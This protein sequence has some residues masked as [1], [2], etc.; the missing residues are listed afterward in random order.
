MR[1]SRRA[2]LFIF[3]APLLLAVALRVPM[4]TAALPYISYI[5]EGHVLHRVMQ[6][7][8]VGTWDPGWYRYPS[9]SMGLIAIVGKLF[10]LLSGGSLIAAIP[11]NH[12][13]YYDLIA[14]PSLILIAR[15]IVLVHSLGIITISTLLIKRLIIS[16]SVLP[17]LC[18]AVLV[19]VIP[20]LHTRSAIVIVDTLAAFY[21][22]L[23]MYL[24][25][26]LRTTD[27]ITLV[28]IL[29]GAACGLAA[30][31]KYQSGSV[32]I[33]VVAVLVLTPQLAALQR[34]KL[35]I[36][37]GCAA[38]VTAL[39]AMPSLLFRFEAVI[40]DL[41][42]QWHIYGSKTGYSGSYLGYA[43]S[44]REFGAGFLLLATAGGV[45]LF[46][47]KGQRAYIIGW[48]LFCIP[49]LILPLR[50]NYQP[51]RNILPL[52][53]PACILIGV[54]MDVALRFS[55][56]FGLVMCAVLLCSAIF[57][58]NK[59]IKTTHLRVQKIDSRAQALDWLAKAATAPVYISAE[60]V[61]LPDELSKIERSV[62]MVIPGDR[63]R[64]LFLSDQAGLFVMEKDVVH[65]DP[66]RDKKP[67]KMFGRRSL[68]DY[69]GYWR[70]NDLGIVVYRNTG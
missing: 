16:D 7:L 18:T 24:C 23:V 70:T 10:D 60:L 32:C 15:L 40:A 13:D 19:A 69:P 46:F 66:F 21:V 3:I 53:A 1:L 8:A 30:A 28:C 5:D 14:P 41:Q 65:T 36:F 49:F 26:L 2:A 20:A 55:R 50:F 34:L 9:F 22:L 17:I 62:A 27:K 37:A 31:A 51:F 64:E 58:L 68:P 44:Y 56:R 45:A 35:L 4:L 29:A 33:V 48:L 61:F 43:L 38:V 25:C 12:S 42:A 54:S 6:M 52:V 67:L 11:Q 47:R 57:L 39:L 63:L 59:D